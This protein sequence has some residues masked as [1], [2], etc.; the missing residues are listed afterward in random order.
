[1]LAYRHRAGFLV[2][3]RSP[4]S[5]FLV[6]VD[7]LLL[8]ST[9]LATRSL[10]CPPC[11]DVSYKLVA[12]GGFRSVESAGWIRA[13]VQQKPGQFTSICVHPIRFS[14]ITNR[15][16]PTIGKVATRWFIRSV[17]V[18]P[19]HVNRVA[20]HSHTLLIFSCRFFCFYSFLFAA[21]CIFSRV[22]LEVSSSFDGAMKRTPTQGSPF[23]A[24]ELKCLHSG[25]ICSLFEYL[26]AFAL[27]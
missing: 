6:A 13:S 14:N 20:H 9:A 26:L 7:T 10:L 3:T 12:L 4:P 18:D 19:D 2:A 22:G 25:R 17:H 27:G 16:S 23:R 11:L 21:V 24:Q 1:M 5:P 8:Y 15:C